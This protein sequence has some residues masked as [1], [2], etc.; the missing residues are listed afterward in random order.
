MARQE[1]RVLIQHKKCRGIV[2]SYERLFKRI[3]ATGYWFLNGK[4]MLG[5]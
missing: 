1:F 2:S 3:S 5:M 4:A